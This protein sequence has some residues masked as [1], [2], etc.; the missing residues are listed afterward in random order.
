MRSALRHY[1]A[2]DE[3]TILRTDAKATVSSKLPRSVRPTASTET[4][5]SSSGASSFMRKLLG[6]RSDSATR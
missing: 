2:W 6:I 5:R 4:R 1:L 3:H